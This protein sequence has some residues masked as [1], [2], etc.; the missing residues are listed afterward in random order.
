[1][2]PPSSLTPA[3]KERVCSKDRHR[4]LS[5]EGM[6]HC[7]FFRITSPRKENCG[8]RVMEVFRRHFRTFPTRE[9]VI[10][11]QGPKTSQPYRDMLITLPSETHR[12]TDEI[13]SVTLDLSISSWLGGYLMALVTGSVLAQKELPFSSKWNLSTLLSRKNFVLFCFEFIACFCFC[14]C[15]FIWNSISLYSPGYPRTHTINQADL[16]RTEI[17]L[18]QL[19]KC[20]DERYR[21]LMFYFKTF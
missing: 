11:P 17:C 3:R 14:C 19:T 12:S 1:M 15:C 21:S 10:V 7:L 8:Y 5:S 20:W 6:L 9:T 16:K 13:V 2:R 18:P 4:S